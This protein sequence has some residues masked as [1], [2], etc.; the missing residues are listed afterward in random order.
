MTKNPGRCEGV[1]RVFEVTRNRRRKISQ[2]SW[3]SY[4]LSSPS[5]PKTTTDHGELLTLTHT[6]QSPIKSTIRVIAVTN[7]GDRCIVRGEH[8]IAFVL[9]AP[10][11]LFCVSDW[12]EPEN[13]VSRTA[14][15][16][17]R[18][19]TTLNPDVF[20]A[21][22]TSRL[23]SSANP[24]GD[25]VYDVVAGVSTAEQFRPNSSAGR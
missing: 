1:L 17:R 5:L 24:L 11:Y 23:Y 25:L 9:K 6:S 15:L 10:I 18:C 7:S 21:P 19:K 12:G 14:D 2:T 13:V 16:D 4:K 8:R 22:S 20:A 3:G